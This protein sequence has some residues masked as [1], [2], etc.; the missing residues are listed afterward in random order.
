MDAG[1]GI[2]GIVGVFVR[3]FLFSALIVC[4]SVLAAPHAQWPEFRGPTGQGHSPEQGLPLDWSESRNVVWKRQ[5]PGRGWSSP[6]VAGS[7]VWLTTAV[8]APG[9]ASLRALAFAVGDRRTAR[10]RRSVPAAGAP[11]R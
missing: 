10:R 2:S 3:A 9:G 7:Q 8:E 6:V 4:L 5:V 1:C 11:M